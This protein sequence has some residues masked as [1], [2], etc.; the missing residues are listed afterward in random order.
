MVIC[1]ISSLHFEAYRKPF[2]IIM[3]LFLLYSCSCPVSPSYE[4]APNHCDSCSDALFPASAAAP[5]S[6]SCSSYSCSQISI[7][8]STYLDRWERDSVE[9]TGVGW[10]VYSLTP[11]CTAYIKSALKYKQPRETGN[12]I[13][14]LKQCNIYIILLVIFP[15]FK[16]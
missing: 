15:T 16:E 11:H 10:L 8:M 4:P 12:T 9:F 7:Q 3:M 13:W 2:K 6:C 5:P 1:F 14:E